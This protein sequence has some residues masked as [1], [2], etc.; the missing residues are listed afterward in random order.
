MKI[1]KLKRQF[2]FNNIIL[3]DPNPSFTVEQVKTF[4]QVQY[5]GL[6]TS[7]SDSGVTNDDTITYTFNVKVG[8]KA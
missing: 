3:P 7:V 4:Y 8:T 2:S 1:K 5:P 6:T